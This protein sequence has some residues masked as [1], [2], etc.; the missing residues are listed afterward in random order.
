MTAAS[1]AR[2]TFGD[3][4]RR[5]A[6]RAWHSPWLHPLNDTQAIN[7]LLAD[8]NPRW[9]LSDIR[10]EL[11]ERSTETADTVSLSFVPNR[12]WPGFVAGQHVAITVDID[13]VRQQRVYS[14]SG[15]PADARRLR[16]TIKRQGRVSTW[17]HEQLRIGDV[18][19]LSAPGGDFVLPATR[20]PLL[21]I[22]AGSGITPM[23]AL[24]HERL[25]R[26]DTPDIVCVHVCRDPDDHI[27]GRELHELAARTPG[28]RLHTIYSAQNRPD[29][30]ALLAAVPDY[31]TR[32]SFLCGPASFMAAVEQRWQHEQLGDRLQLERFGLPPRAIDDGQ[33]AEVRCAKSDRVFTAATVDALLP[34]AEAAGLSPA[35][36]CRIGICRTCL[37]RKTSGVVENL[38]SG[39]RSSAGEEWIRLCVSAPRSDLELDL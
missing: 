14:L 21:L 18:V 22:S 33:R 12:L 13:G 37:C 26:G 32:R 24:L 3:R 23:R 35:Y 25:A 1:S 39:E 30:D 2:P 34:T 19:T 28:L 15:D 20:E 7:E 29:I 36:G 16:L 6:R 8:V 9:S 5:G 17:L 27:F 31:A 10:A 38:V 4:L 11:V